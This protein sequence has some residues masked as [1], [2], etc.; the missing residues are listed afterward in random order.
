[1]DTWKIREYDVL[2][3][4]N[5]EARRLVEAMQN[6]VVESQRIAEPWTTPESRTA[7][8]QGMDAL[9]KTVIL[10]RE[11]TAGRGRRGRQWNSP[12]GENLY[13]SQIL[14]PEL[15]AEAVSALT[16]VMGLAAAESVR[17]LTGADA[18]IKW[19][20]DIVI[21][22][23]KVC[24]I[25][26]EMVLDGAKLDAVIIGVGVNVGIQEFPAELAQTATSLEQA[27]R[28]NI[29]PS[30]LLAAILEQFSARYEAYCSVGNMSGLL[31]PYNAL[32]A[33]RDREVCVL[34]PQGNYNGT[35]RGINEKGELL[36]ELADGTV[37]A[38]YAGEVSVRGIY[39]YV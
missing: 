23:K 39:G 36:V 28:K 22:G 13:F 15:S 3:S 25:L 32:L 10:A 29:S 2:D 19:P 27:C 17:E 5:L 24:G 37:N 11:Q 33:N 31:E 12:A 21:G 1:M 18:L 9:H 6:A 26:A 16:L 8:E 4:T 30:E 34:E 14:Q 7:A 35:A 38:V 20:N